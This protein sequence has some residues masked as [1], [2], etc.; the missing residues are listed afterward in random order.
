VDTGHGAAIGSRSYGDDPALV[1]RVGAAAVKGFARADLVS[2]AKHFPNHR[3]ALED[4]R[5][6]RLRIDYDM[7]TVVQRNLSRFRVAI[8]AGVPVVMVG[9]LVYPDRS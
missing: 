4:S 5:V 6:E 8:E 9:H 1:G 3:P 2:A 7:Q